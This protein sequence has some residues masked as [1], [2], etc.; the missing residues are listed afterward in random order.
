MEIFIV[1]LIAW[2]AFS[3]LVA[4]VAAERQHDRVLY[5]LYSLLLSP[6]IALLILLA[7]GSGTIGMVKCPSC[8]EYVRSDATRCRYCQTEL[9]P[10]LS[11]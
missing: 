11:S 10:T 3:F 9:R 7:S 4:Q 5:F 1:V 6:V 2:V 8:A